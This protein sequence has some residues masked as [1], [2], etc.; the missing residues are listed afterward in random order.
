MLI[1][2]PLQSEWVIEFWNYLTS[3]EGYQAIAIRSKTANATDTIE[4]RSQ[5]FKNLDPFVALK[6]PESSK[7]NK[8]PV[9]QDDA[10]E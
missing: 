3:L 8:E 6:P 4:R 1:L 9:M 5:N 7:K 10:N 2:Q